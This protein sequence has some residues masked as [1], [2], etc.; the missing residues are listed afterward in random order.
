[1]QDAANLVAQVNADILHVGEV[2]GCHVLKALLILLPPDN[3][4]RP[5]LVEGNDRTLGHQVGILTRI[6]PVIVLSHNLTQVT[7]SLEEDY[8]RSVGASKNYSTLFKI[9]NTA[10]EETMIGLTGLHLLSGANGDMHST[11]RR[12]IQATIIIDQVMTSLEAN[13]RLKVIVLGDMN[14]YDSMIPNATLLFPEGKTLDILRSVKPD[15]VNA[16]QGFPQEKC[17]T[18]E[19]YFTGIRGVLDHALV[20]PGLRIAGVTIGH[21]WM[22]EVTENPRISDHVLVLVELDVS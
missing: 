17:Y 11:Y 4:Y 13:D 8:T 1:M 14:V 16:L 21:Q 2:E 6:D 3:G 10:E 20:D 15:L 18:H 9:K 5:Y 22:S 12:E 7:C 19:D